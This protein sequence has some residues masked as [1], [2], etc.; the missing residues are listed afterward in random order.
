MITDMRYSQHILETGH[1][2]GNVESTLEVIKRSQKRKMSGY[3]REISHIPSKQ[4]MNKY[5]LIKSTM[6]VGYNL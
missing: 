2:Y 4:I 6:S 3:S 1:T 5:E